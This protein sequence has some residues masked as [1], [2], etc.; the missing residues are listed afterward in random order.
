MCKGFLL[1]TYNYIEPWKITP[2]QQQYFKFLMIFPVRASWIAIASVRKIKSKGEMKC[3]KI[4]LKS[5][6]ILPIFKFLFHIFYCL[7]KTVIYVWEFIG[8]RPKN[9]FYRL[10]PIQNNIFNSTPKFLKI[11]LWI[12][13]FNYSFIG[14]ARG[15]HRER[16]PHPEIEKIVV[17]KWCYFRR[18]Y[19]QQQL[20]QK[21]IKIQFF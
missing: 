7:Y 10:I 6:N 14:A 18:L 8:K 12:L 4:F 20:F 1:K 16:S 11:I 19:F 2:F 15:E 5:L 13:I 9:S 21:Q 17:E 3:L